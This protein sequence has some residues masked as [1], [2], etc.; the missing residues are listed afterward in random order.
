LVQVNSLQQLISINQEVGALG[1]TASGSGTGATGAGGSVMTAGALSSGA[2]SSATPAAAAAG[3]KQ[4]AA[5]VAAE[6][7]HASPMQA[8]TNFAATLRGE[9]AAPSME[10][11]MAASA[12]RVAS[13]L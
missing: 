2:A 4:A 1:T 12:R 8:M 7:L 6:G 5:E 3:V 9:P 13:A 10:A 11:T